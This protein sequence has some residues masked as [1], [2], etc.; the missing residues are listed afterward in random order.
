[1]DRQAR[2]GHA[3]HRSRL[4]GRPLMVGIAEIV[5]RAR[6][7]HEWRARDAADSGAQRAQRLQLPLRDVRHLEGERRTAARS[8][9]RRSPITSRHPPAARAARH[10]DRRRAAAQP[11]TCG[12]CASS[13]EANGIRITL[14]TTGLLIEQPCRGDR[15]SYRHG[16]DLARWAARRARR[17]P[18]GQDGLRAH[19]RGV[20]ALQI[21][22]RCRRG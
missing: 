4:R 10:A 15:A 18:P 20:V 8:R 11:A 17:D 21:R 22:S 16:C 6:G 1:M 5:R 2:R 9:R 3:D 19:R 13:C 12:R 7:Q 14:V